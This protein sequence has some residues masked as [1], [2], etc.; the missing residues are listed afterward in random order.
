MSSAPSCGKGFF[1]EAAQ[2]GAACLECPEPG[3]SVLLLLLAC[4]TYYTVLLGV[5]HLARQASRRRGVAVFV[6]VRSALEHFGALG[7]LGTMLAT[8]PVVIRAATWLQGFGFV[9]V[10]LSGSPLECV[11]QLEAFGTPSLAVRT[12]VEVIIV[13]LGASLVCVQ[14]YYFAA[15]DDD[16]RSLV[17]CG[18]LRSRLCP[19]KTL[20]P[21]EKVVLDHLQRVKDPNSSMSAK[22]HLMD[23]ALMPFDADGQHATVPC[24]VDDEL[25]T[26]DEDLTDES[27]AAVDS[28]I[29]S[30]LVVAAAVR[31]ALPSAS[32][33][34]LAEAVRSRIGS[35][36]ALPPTALQQVMATRLEAL[37]GELAAIELP[38]AEDEERR[39]KIL[40]GRAVENVA[41]QTPGTSAHA[42]ALREKMAAEHAVQLAKRRAD[43]LR[44]TLQSSP[45][46]A[47]STVPG[48]AESLEPWERQHLSHRFGVLPTDSKYFALAARGSGI[49]EAAIDELALRV[50]EGRQDALPDEGVDPADREA[51]LDVPL[52]VRVDDSGAIVASVGP[53]AAARKARDSLASGGIPEPSWLSLASSGRRGRQDRRVRS[54]ALRCLCTAT[55]ELFCCVGLCEGRPCGCHSQDRAAVAAMDEDAIVIARDGPNRGHFDRVPCDTGDEEKDSEEAAMEEG[56]GPGGEGPLPG[57]EKEAVAEAKTDEGAPLAIWVP[58]ASPRSSPVDTESG[59]GSP[60]S[61]GAPDGP[62]ADAGPGDSSPPPVLAQ[63]AAGIAAASS[64]SVTREAMARLA[65]F[66]QPGADDLSLRSQAER[67]AAREAKEAAAAAALAEQAAVDYA[68]DFFEEEAEQAEA[69][70]LIDAEEEEAMRE[71]E[72]Q[73]GPVDDMDPMPELGMPEQRDGD[74]ATA[75]REE[76]EAR[77]ESDKL[78]ASSRQREACFA[79][80]VAVLS[81]VAAAGDS[82]LDGF[83]DAI[84]YACHF[85]AFRLTG[86]WPVLPPSPQMRAAMA[87]RLSEAAVH[88]MGGRATGGAAKQEEDGDGQDEANERGGST[89]ASS[90][91]VGSGGDTKGSGVRAPVSPRGDARGA[92]A[93]TAGA[94]DGP[95]TEVDEDA[96]AEAGAETDGSP[97]QGG[98]EMPAELE[99]GTQAGEAAQDDMVPGATVVESQDGDS[100]TGQDDS[101]PAGADGAAVAKGLSIHIEHDSMVDLTAGIRGGGDVGGPSQGDEMRGDSDTDSIGWNAGGTMRRPESRV[102]FSDLQAL[103]TADGTVAVPRG[104]AP[105][106]KPARAFAHLSTAVEASASDD[107]D[108]DDADAKVAVPAAPVQPAPEGAAGEPQPEAAAGDDGGESGAASSPVASGIGGESKSL[109]GP[110]PD[111]KEGTTGTDDAPPAVVGMFGASI[112]RQDGNLSAYSGGGP[113]L[114]AFDSRAARAFAV[115]RRCAELQASDDPEARLMDA[116]IA[117]LPPGRAGDGPTAAAPAA[118]SPSPEGRPPPIPVAT[119][120]APF[121][122]IE[123]V[124]VPAGLSERQRKRSV[125]RMSQ[126]NLRGVRASKPSVKVG[127][128]G[129]PS[130]G[131]SA[132]A[133]TGRDG[134]DGSKVASPMDAVRV[135]GSGSALASPV[136][137]GASPTE[138]ADGS[139]AASVGEGASRAYLTAHPRSTAWVSVVD[140]SVHRLV[141]AAAQALEPLSTVGESELNAMAR[142]LKQLREEGEQE[143]ARRAA[144]R[145]WYPFLLAGTVSMPTVVARAALAFSFVPTG[146]ADRPLAADAFITAGSDAA[147]AAAGVA[148]TVIAVW[149][150]LLLV[151]AGRLA[152]PCGRWHTL[153]ADTARRV[154]LAPVTLGYRAGCC[155]FGLVVAVTTAVVGIGLASAFAADERH[156]VLAALSACA[157]VAFAALGPRPST[158][159]APFT[160]WPLATAALMLLIGAILPTS[161]SAGAADPSFGMVLLNVLTV[162]LWLAFAASAAGPCAASCPGCGGGRNA[163]SVVVDLASRRLSAYVADKAAPADGALEDLAGLADPCC[164]HLVSCWRLWPFSDAGMAERRVRDAEDSARATLRRLRFVGRVTRGE[165]LSLPGLRVAGRPVA[166]PSQL[167]LS[168]PRTMLRVSPAS[169]ASRPLAPDLWMAWGVRGHPGLCC[170]CG[171]HEQRRGNGWL[172]PDPWHVIS[173]YGTKVDLSAAVHDDVEE[174]AAGPTDADRELHAAYRGARAHVEVP[175]DPDAVASHTLVWACLPVCCAR[176]QPGKSTLPVVSEGLDPHERAELVDAVTAEL[177]VEQARRASA[178]IAFELRARDMPQPTLLQVEEAARLEAAHVVAAATTVIREAQVSGAEEAVAARLALRQ[179]RRRTADRAAVLRGLEQKERKQTLERQARRLEEAA[180]AER[181]RM[182]VAVANEAR[183]VEDAQAEAK[184]RRA[185]ERLREQALTQTRRRT[186]T[187]CTAKEYQADQTLAVVDGMTD[188]LAE[189]ER[190]KARR[191]Q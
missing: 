41:A 17:A 146:A 11:L 125:K 3:W 122:R 114:D 23:L 161:G 14:G 113:D 159:V 140:A 109:M 168:A 77:S 87:L 149:L 95:D 42:E 27:G 136:S 157:L 13:L 6:V 57:A 189:M 80:W 103:P 142:Q 147:T 178:L 188:L 34:R 18:R 144:A 131:G 150:A 38:D 64:G 176:A 24:A 82:R 181:E 128:A 26:G 19:S 47:V 21:I 79:R 119:R 58:G 4:A 110:P 28:G 2:F 5:V 73:L 45:E 96:V 169:E 20:E 99:G 93:G 160:M 166:Q 62:A 54:S 148:G 72:E 52:T 190:D 179:G 105:A 191:R 37:A 108:E 8:A 165:S 173:G 32:Q 120:I 123:P 151:L 16:V 60:D 83:D 97:E 186:L 35:V 116:A 175:T 104:A 167:S 75:P 43:G 50:R 39:H 78:A 67:D 118:R 183:V 130:E 162:L 177:A 115:A 12:A 51:L 36:R 90:S 63:V 182:A 127:M 94:A 71:D 155:G 59:A 44:H 29:A 7:T 134:S 139:T 89:P 138:G 117:E 81:D 126:R 153:Y 143:E 10:A 112:A 86:V 85:E 101:D 92:V 84:A 174:P 152:F 88:A 68:M 106:L 15:P 49:V 111:R 135:V 65:T 187:D 48:P 61:K 91:G 164:G 133:S 185:Q 172:L 180:A 66:R 22:R 56:A 1:A 132:G 98:V 154:A 171:C 170:C 70:G 40:V 69:M 102:A 145:C 74:G 55:R 184:A 46:G 158:S 31:A 137:R 129:P 107:D 156:A 76:D 121:A 25:D 100:V 163:E 9:S 33:G 53:W 141:V 30:H 124:P